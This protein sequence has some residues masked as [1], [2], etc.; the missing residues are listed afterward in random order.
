[1][2]MM[3]LAMTALLMLVSLTA[4]AATG[5]VQVTDLRVENMTN[6]LGLD[7]DRPR[8][9]WKL[10]ADVGGVVQTAYELTVES[11]GRV[12]WNSGRVESRQQLWVPYGG[13]PL[14]SG[15]YCTYRVRVHTNKGMT[16]WSQPHPFSIGLLGESYWSGRWI[17]LTPQPSTLNAQPSTLNTPPSTLNTQHSTLNARYLRKEFTVSKPVRRA[18]AYVAGLG[19][20]EFYINGKRQGHHVLQPIPSDYRKTIYYNTYDVTA[21]LTASNCLG[22]VLGNGRF[23]AP[24]QDKPYKNTQFGW[25]VCRLNLIID[26]ADGSRERIV[27]DETWRVT[28]DGPIRANN[29]YDGEVYDARCEMPGWSRCG[30]DDSSW[31]QAERMAL[32]QG[33]LRGQTAEGMTAT[34][35]TKLLT[36]T[37]RA[38]RRFIVDCGQNLAGWISLT[39][40]GRKGDTI[41]IRYAERLQADGSLYTDNLRDAQSQDTYVCGGTAAEGGAF[42]PTFV[43]HGFR[44]VEITGMDEVKTSDVQAWL[45]ADEMATTGHFACS[46]TTLTRVIGNAWW[47]IASNYK[48]MPVDCP[49]RNERQPWLGDRTV[50]ALG[51]S[52]LFGNERLYSKWTRDICEAQREDGC[53]P[54]VAPAFWNY[55]TDDVTWPAALPFVCDMISRQYGNDEPL[56]RCY[57]NMVRWMEHLLDR[58]VKDG[59]VTKDKYGDWC[60]PPEKPELIHSEAPERKTDGSLIATAYTIGCM[61]LLERFARQQGLT[62]DAGYWARRADIMKADFN[63]KFLH[64]RPHTSPRPGHPLYPDSTFYGNNTAT[65]NLLAL[66]FGIAPDSIR[67]DVARQVV[68]N[69]VVKNKI[70]LTTGVIGTSWLMRELAAGGYGE[71]AYALATQKTYPSWGYMVEHGATTIWELWNGDTAHPAMNSGNHVMLLGDLITWAYE[72]VG[73][74]SNP[75]GGYAE[76]DLAPAFYSLPDCS[77]ADVSYESLYGPIVSRWTKRDGH[78]VW[79]VEVPCNTTAR[80]MLPDAEYTTVGSGSHHYEFDIDETSFLYERAP[81][82]SP[83]AATI[84]E[85][86]QGELVAAYF[87]GTYERNPDCNIWVQILNGRGTRCFGRGTESEV[88][89]ARYEVRSARYANSQE[90]RANS[91]QSRAEEGGWSAPILA[92][93]GGGVACWNPVLVEIPDSL[94]PLSRGS[95]RGSELWLFYKVGVNVKSWTGWLTKS[96]DG[97]RTWSQPEPLPEGFL[98]PIKNKPLLLGDRLLCGSSTEADGWRFHVEILDLKTNRWHYVGPVE[99]T[100]AAPT[101]HPDTLAPIDCIQPSFLQLRDGRLQVLMRSKNGRLATSFSSD[102]GETW[103]PVTLSELP[104]NQSGT[105]AVTL[106]DGRHVLVYN[107]FATIP[108]TPKGP[109][110][111]LSVAISSDDGRSWQHLCTLESSPVGEY[112]YPAVIEGRDGSIHVVYTWRRQRIAYKRLKP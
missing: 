33:T 77:W 56:R 11:D 64:C 39:P 42:H 74:I 13:T 30:F 101:L 85:T 38:P 25:P 45:V 108:G 100:L 89:G 105:D 10:T 55:Y 41:R 36:V 48:G 20:H 98:G 32:P 57:P 83:H 26:Y 54:D 73:G 91:Q 80:I 86:Q 27:T 94:L 87:G 8:F 28:A 43:T 90:L 9:S 23:F 18:M 6:P 93:D 111:P 50:G 109:R 112:S 3:K 110:T 19:L 12:L 97:G 82:A 88:R 72:S 58:Y 67:A 24:R 34:P 78:V 17:G 7:T 103:T 35:V 107:D 106:H 21:A 1:M 95:Q 92:A 104:N 79:D 5:K 71:L 16:E 29:E 4:D 65:A 102:R 40:R 66:A 31:Q 76:F 81:F 52:F 53:I 46:D 99:S 47:G 70:H 75:S 62:D 14:K 15:Q 61:Q 49:Q 37:R 2:P 51:E 59:I 84:V 68:E 22:I 44:Y 60:V 96:R 69:I 63:R